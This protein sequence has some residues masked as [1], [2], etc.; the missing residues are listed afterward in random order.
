MKKII[1]GLT[2]FLVTFTSHSQI[3]ISMLF[4]DKLNSDGLEFGL[5]GGINFSQISGMET[6]S[7][8]VA[9]NLGYYFDIRIKNQWN[10]YTGMLVKSNFG[11]D[12]LTENDLNSLGATINV[13]KGDYKQVIKAFQLPVLA[14]YHFKNHFYLELGPQF[15][16]MYDAYIQF[17]SDIEGKNIRIRDNNKDILRTLDAGVVGGFGYKLMNGEGFTVGL[18]YY[19]GFTDVYKN[20]SGTT[21]SS[22]FLKINIPIGSYKEKEES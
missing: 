21:N 11:S 16:L 13:E 9:Y 20:I 5:E 12:N 8:M 1:V 2:L 18:K 15:A 10:L 19:Q 17:D 3:L 14:K 4:G 6:S 22:L 7:S